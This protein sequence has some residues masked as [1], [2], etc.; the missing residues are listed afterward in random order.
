MARLIRM[1][2]AESLAIVVGMCGRAE[3]AFVL[4]AIGL[5]SGG[6]TTTPSP[7]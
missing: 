7:Y 5:S 2:Y 6:S 4:A 1:N 3:M